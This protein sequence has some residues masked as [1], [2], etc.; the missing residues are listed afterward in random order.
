LFGNLLPKQDDNEKEKQV[1]YISNYEALNIPDE[2][3]LIAD[4]HSY[5]F[6][7]NNALFFRR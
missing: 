6:N 2:K 4:W 3:G 1:K 7:P 5:R